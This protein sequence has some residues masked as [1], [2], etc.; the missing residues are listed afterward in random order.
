V[1]TCFAACLEFGSQVHFVKNISSVPHTLR[2]NHIHP[3]AVSNHK[4]PRRF[5]GRE[6]VTE[7]RVVVP[8]KFDLDES[9]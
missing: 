4:K 8:P 1:V 3:S 2:K 7:K 5:S 9:E 6:V